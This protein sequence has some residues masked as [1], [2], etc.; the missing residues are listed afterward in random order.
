MANF[1]RWALA[2]VV[3][4]GLI[5][6]VGSSVRAAEGETGDPK[7]LWAEGVELFDQGQFEKAKAKFDALVPL[8]DDKTA[9]AL[10][11]RAGLRAMIRIL[12][13]KNVG[14]GPSVIWEL[15]SK[16]NRRRMVDEERIARVVAQVVDEKMALTQ[17]VQHN[18]AMRELRDLGQYAVPELAKQLETKSDQQRTLIRIALSHIGARGTLATVKLLDTGSDLAKET[19]ALALGD[20]VPADARAVPA[21]KR[22]YDN[23]KTTPRVRENAGRAL[24]KITGLRASDLKPF[25]DHYYELADRYY[26]ELS[27]VPDEA[28]EADGV[29]WKLEDG[30]L[31]RRSVPVYA[32]NEEMAEDLAFECLAGAPEYERILPLLV[33]VELAQREETASML[34][35]I[36]AFGAPPAITEKDQKILAEREKLMVDAKLLAESFGPHI[37]YRA[38]GK[39]LKDN[40]PLV[41]AAAIDLLPQLDPRGD[42]LPGVSP[43][44]LAATAAEPAKAEDKPKKKSW[45]RL[46]GDDEKEKAA[47]AEAAVAAAKAAAA[48]AEGQPLVEALACGDDGVAVSAA[49]AIAAMDPP[50][51]FPGSEKVMAKLADAVSKAGPLQI[52]VVDEDDNSFK[53]LK[54]AI[55]EQGWGASRA[56]SGRDALA[57][58]S[59]FPPKDLVVVSSALKADLKPEELLAE[60]KKDVTLSLLPVAV[61]VNRADVTKEQARFGNLCM[62]AR[63]EK[64]LELKNVLVKALGQRG[65]AVTKQKR[66]ALAV[67][68]AEAMLL[69]DPRRT[70][71]VPADAVASCRAALVN[72]PDEVRIPCA[73]VLGYFA[74]KD[75]V[76]DLLRVFETK[77][78]ALPLRANALWALG[79]TDPAASRKAFLAAQK[80]EKEF[81]LR[82]LAAQGY[83]L[84]MPAAKENT[85]FQQKCRLQRSPDGGLVEGAAA[86]APAPAPTPAPETPAAAPAAAAPA[87]N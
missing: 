33:C 41:C 50:R 36:K 86:S 10:V 40:R 81:S 55:E 63:E 85:D 79:R 30:K 72:R 58:V 3:L 70:Q 14:R 34:E 42:L 4:G 67:K 62:V 75:A 25:A 35:A 9:A 57:K 1:S 59:V 74:A 61:L 84:S 19:V 37:V 13:E 45:W 73:R 7:K 12:A 24:E 20:I 16:Y 8:L 77:T 54:L 56:A 44:E 5:L 49:A 60:L 83:G 26:L 66:E 22:L 27:G 6:S 2:A 64:G 65:P 87:V 39:A 80:D 69:V 38:V 51:P 53:E 29:L 18:R 78:N 32:W 76:S 52:L 23:P 71:M 31:V 17:P 82:D 43:V 68:A 11:E 21:L 28:L 46:G 15:Y 47:K 48:S